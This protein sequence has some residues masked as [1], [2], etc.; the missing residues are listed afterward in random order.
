MW[1]AFAN[2]THALLSWLSSVSTTDILSMQD[3]AWSSRAVMKQMPKNE[4]SVDFGRKDTF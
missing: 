1:L 2:H 3:R 4:T